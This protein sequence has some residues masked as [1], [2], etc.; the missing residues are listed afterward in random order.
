MNL[1]LPTPFL[2]MAYD[3]WATLRG[4]RVMPARADFDPMDIPRALPNIV[5]IEVQKEPLDF[6]Y[7]V[8]GSVIVHHSATSFSGQWM[9]EI[10]E[11]R[12]PNAPWMNCQKVVESCKPSRSTI[13]YVGPH[14]EFLET[15]QITLPLS[16]AVDARDVTHLLLVI[17]YLSR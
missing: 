17:D 10:P 4:D 8:V 5:L 1:P 11:R 16:S 9:S 14:K 2:Q 7:R 6:L 15:T 3:H 12:S 13:P